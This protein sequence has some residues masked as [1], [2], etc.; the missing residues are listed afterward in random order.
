M[1]SRSA[2]HFVAGA[3]AAAF[4]VQVLWTLSRAATLND[5]RTLLSWIVPALLGSLTMYFSTA[6]RLAAASP[7]VEHQA[8]SE[9]STPVRPR[10]A[11]YPTPDRSPREKRTRDVPSH[12]PS[13]PS[14]VEEVLFGPP[15]SPLAA[16]F[17]RQDTPGRGIDPNPTPRRLSRDR[18]THKDSAPVGYHSESDS[19]P[20]LSAEEERHLMRRFTTGCET[21]NIKVIRQCL[22]VDGFNP[23]KDLRS[24]RTGFLI[25]CARGHRAVVTELLKPS[26]RVDVNAREAF[27]GQSGL[28]LAC[29]GDHLSVVE[30]LLEC[31]RLDVNARDS[32]HAT[33]LF[34]ACA[35][36]KDRLVER[37]FTGDRVD[38]NARDYTGTTPFVAA[39]FKGQVSTLDLLLQHQ[40]KID[41]TLTSKRKIDEVDG[42][43]VDR[44]T[45]QGTHTADEWLDFLNEPTRERVKFALTK[46]AKELMEKAGSMRKVDKSAVSYDENKWLGG[47]SFGDVYEGRYFVTEECAVKVLRRSTAME[48]FEQEIKSWDRVG[49]HSKVLPLMAYVAEPGK[50]L[51][52]TK[53]IRNGNVREYLEARCWDHNLAAKLLLDIAMGMSY[54]HFKDCLHGDLKAENVLVN[55]AGTAMISDFGLSQVRLSASAMRPGNAGG[56]P[57]FMAPELFRGMDVHKKSDVW[58]FGMV[59]FEL[60]GRGAIPFPGLPP[61]PIM[62]LITKGKTPNRPNGTPDAV[63]KLMKQCWATD[64]EGRPSFLELVEEL[65]KLQPTATAAP[66]GTSGSLAAPSSSGAPSHSYSRTRSGSTR[67]AS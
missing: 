6:S 67:T 15:D 8:P 39:A 32:S 65:E 4:T 61:A 49:N 35:S 50:L 12:Q 20:K 7:P 52:V 53:L 64:P 19:E 25:A 37:F 10:I 45:G 59:M 17:P 60:F 51:M 22:A 11:D 31:K 47:G 33:P 28:H 2:V 26:S 48:S 14:G 63:W 21:G 58:A 42:R 9:H 46:R 38:F 43:K 36:G 54:L 62:L 3:I 1:Q 29:L 55:D 40:D 66:D 23:E 16:R 13:L 41:I 34:M 57:I 56:T 18:S 5:V 27:S 44:F 30:L 24:N